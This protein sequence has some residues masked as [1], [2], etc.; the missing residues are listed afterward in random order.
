MGKGRQRTQFVWRSKSLKGFSIKDTNIQ[1]RD[2]CYRKERG[3]E[4]TSRKPVLLA[5]GTHLNRREGTLFFTCHAVKVYSMFWFMEQKQS[6]TDVLQRYNLTEPEVGDL[7]DFQRRFGSGNQEDLRLLGLVFTSLCLSLLNH[8][9]LCRQASPDLQSVGQTLAVPG[10]PGWHVSQANFL[11]QL[12]LAA[13]CRCI[14][15]E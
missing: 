14:R 3:R 11:S 5:K 2:Y 4:T 12:P 15:R 1:Q 8:I 10:L 9:C 13:T 6:A 7:A